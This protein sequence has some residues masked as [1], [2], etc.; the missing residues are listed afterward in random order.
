MAEQIRVAVGEPLSF[1][2]E[3]L[4][5]RGHAIEC[6]IY[7]E[8]PASGFLPSAGPILLMEEP[9]GPGVRVDSGVYSGGEVSVHYDPIM[10]KLIAWGPDREAAR[11]R[12]VRALEEYPVL[13]IKTT[14]AF[15]KD[16][17]EHPEFIAGNT[18]TN[19]IE[20]NLPDWRPAADD[21]LLG[22]ALA[23]AALSEIEPKAV[24][25]AAKEEMPSPWRTIGAWQ[26]GSGR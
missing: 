8:D 10:A 20:E 22:T 21:E 1:K 25:A 17:M 5:Q 2:Q 13:G 26:I 23:A 7:A 24:T 11:R 16:I 6:R 18:H 9:R 12:I 14:V 19:F 3:D 4:S 15:L